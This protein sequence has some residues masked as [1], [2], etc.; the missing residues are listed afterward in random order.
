MLPLTGIEPSTLG[1][2]VVL[3]SCVYSLTPRQLY[4]FPTEL[5]CQVLIERYLT[6]LSFEYQSIF[7][8]REL[9]RQNQRA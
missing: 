2:S 1:L 8:L 9:F 7:G 4:L 6:P 3:T 5:S